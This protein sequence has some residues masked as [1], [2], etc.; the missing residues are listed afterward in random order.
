MRVCTDLCFTWVWV[1]SCLFGFNT[2]IK[3]VY[4]WFGGFAGVVVLWFGVL[5]VAFCACYWLFY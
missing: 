1:L 5:I 4:W 3:L 2:V